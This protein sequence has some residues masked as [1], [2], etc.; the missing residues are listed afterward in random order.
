MG[1]LVYRYVSAVALIGAVLSEKP[2]LIVQAPDTPVRL[3]RATVLTS[4]DAPP[5]VL[6]S[7]TNTTADNIDQ[8]TVI[9]Y[10]FDAQGTLKAR[11]SAPARRELEAHASKF[12]AIVLDG[13]PIQPTDQIVIG[14]NQA[15]KVGS[16]TW[17]RAELQ[18]AAMAAV[19]PAKQ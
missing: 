15:Q 14:V 12:S 18:Q 6:Y 3:D 13:S 1:A 4:A 11:Q 5:V 7:A 2:G 19:R 17:W 16:D 9:V 10:V 8:F